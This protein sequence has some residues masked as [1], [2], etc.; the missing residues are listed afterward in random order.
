MAPAGA[1][2]T[3][4]KVAVPSRFGQVFLCYGALG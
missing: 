2:G 1:A 4:S 3:Q